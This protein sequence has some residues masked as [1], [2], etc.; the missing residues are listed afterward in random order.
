MIDSLII[1]I[2]LVLLLIYTLKFVIMPNI[3][4]LLHNDVC[5]ESVGEMLALVNLGQFSCRMICVEASYIFYSVN[6]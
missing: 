6:R 2:T 3:N 5:N 4:N 1:Y